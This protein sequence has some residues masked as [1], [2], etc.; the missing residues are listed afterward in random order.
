MKTDSS[1]APPIVAKLIIK[2]KMDRR[3]FMVEVGRP[4]PGLRSAPGWPTVEPRAHRRC[5]APHRFFR[6]NASGEDGSLHPSETL[7]QPRLHLPHSGRCS[8]AAPSLIA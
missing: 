4:V 5:S 2:T 3:V 7:T 8:G 1:A 6:T